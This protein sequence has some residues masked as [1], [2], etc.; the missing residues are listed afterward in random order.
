MPLTAGLLLAAGEVATS[1][2][3]PWPSDDEIFAA[4]SVN[5]AGAREL[6]GAIGAFLPALARS[7]IATRESQ[8]VAV[9]STA[10]HLLGTREDWTRGTRLATAASAASNADEPRAAKHDATPA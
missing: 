8:L 6:E 2:G 9:A 10:L 5:R 3:L 7:P 4:T 1:H